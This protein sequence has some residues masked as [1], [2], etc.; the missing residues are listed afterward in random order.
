[1]FGN[2]EGFVVSGLGTGGEDRAEAMS[3]A[4]TTVRAAGKPMPLQSTGLPAGR[5]RCVIRLPMLRT[6]FEACK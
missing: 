6:T 4:K 3:Q 1:M 5:K 2:P